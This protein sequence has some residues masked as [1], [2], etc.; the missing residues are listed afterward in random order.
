MSWRHRATLQEGS[1]SSFLRITWFYPVMHFFA[2]PLD[3]PIFQQGTRH[4]Y[5]AVSEKNSLPFH[6]PIPSIPVMALKL[7]LVTRRCS[8]PFLDNPKEFCIILLVIIKVYKKASANLLFNYILRKRLIEIE[9][10]IA[11]I[12][13]PNPKRPPTIIGTKRWGL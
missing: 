10:P 11:P 4:S 7:L 3:G 1:P 9:E 6:L 2:K 13:I 12:K 5:L 8:I